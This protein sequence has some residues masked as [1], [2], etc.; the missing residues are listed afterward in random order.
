MVTYARD[1]IS[2]EEMFPNL[3]ANS[4]SVSVAPTSNGIPPRSMCQPVAT[5]GSISL[6]THLTITVPRAMDCA[7]RSI[8]NSPLPKSPPAPL[9]PIAARVALTSDAIPPTPPMLGSSRTAS[10]ATPSDKPKKAFGEI[11]SPRNSAARIATLTG[12]ESII[13]LPMP[14]PVRWI[15]SARKPWKHV[16]S[17]SA[18]TRIL[19]QSMPFFGKTSPPLCDAHRRRRTPAGMSLVAPR[20]RGVVCSDTAFMAT[21]LVPQKKKGDRRDAYPRT[22]LPENTSLSP[23]SPPP[24]GISTSFVSSSASSSFT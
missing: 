6:H 22:S 17:T 4:G 16:P 15:P 1:R 7:A 8:K 10:P 3:P 5:T 24:V 14:A 2:N 20:K 23:P 11:V 19:N 13:T 9:P 12:C 21:M 18:K